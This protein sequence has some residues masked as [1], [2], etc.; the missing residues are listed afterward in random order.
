MSTTPFGLRPTRWYRCVCLRQFLSEVVQV[1]WR[2]QAVKEHGQG[3]ACVEVYE[4]MSP[5]SQN[6]E[7]LS[8]HHNDQSFIAFII[9]CGGLA[10]V[11]TF[12]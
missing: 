3:W 11:Q 2:L 4:A 9:D 12:W 6:L 5:D 1:T 7:P 8:L 10:C